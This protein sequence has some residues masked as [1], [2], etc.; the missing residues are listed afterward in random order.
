MRKILIALLI[1]VIFSSCEQPVATNVE[2]GVVG[3]EVTLPYAPFNSSKTIYEFDY[4]GHTYIASK[5][6]DGI[7]PAH[8]G[9]CWCNKQN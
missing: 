3:G 8:A 1:A 2:T 6:R 5:V 9:H 4:K 7:A